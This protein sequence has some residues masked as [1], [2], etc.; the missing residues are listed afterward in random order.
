MSKV[1]AKDTGKYGKHSTGLSVQ[2]SID[3]LDLRSTARPV[4]NNF[5]RGELG[6]D[7]GRARA[8]MPAESQGP[9]V[10]TFGPETPPHPHA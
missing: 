3:Q 8:N 1:R 2:P 6:P 9:T 5:Q 4:V 7:A 10:P